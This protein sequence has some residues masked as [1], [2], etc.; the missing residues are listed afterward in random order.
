MDLETCQRVSEVLS[1]IHIFLFWPT[2]IGNPPK[3][4]VRY[5]DYASDKVALDLFS[6]QTIKSV[7]DLISGD[8]GNSAVVVVSLEIFCSQLKDCC[9]EGSKCIYLVRFVVVHIVPHTGQHIP[10]QSEKYCAGICGS[11][12]SCSA[13]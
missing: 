1:L 10:H 11:A 7:I 4:I 8:V 9:L 5:I 6:S 12:I 3:D 13:L 2:K